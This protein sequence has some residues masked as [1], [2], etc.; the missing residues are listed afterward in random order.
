MNWLRNWVS[1]WR[2]TQPEPSVMSS[3]A[4]LRCEK[5]IDLSVS[6]AVNLDR[7]WPVRS[8]WRFLVPAAI[9]CLFLISCYDFTYP[10][11][12]Y[13]FLLSLLS[14][15]FQPY[16]QPL[17]ALVCTFICA[18]V[19]VDLFCYTHPSM[20]LPAVIHTSPPGWIKQRIVKSLSL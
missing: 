2:N 10:N 5:L 15:G 1:L 6:T 17:L 9:D 12:S 16:L 14:A 3:Y 13:I 11:I 7:N 19:W 8:V 4:E 18:C 20:S